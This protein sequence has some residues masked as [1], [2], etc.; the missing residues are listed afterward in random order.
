M[1]ITDSKASFEAHCCRVDPSNTI[2]NLLARNNIETFSALAFAIGT[3]QSPPTD[4]QFR[5][6][7][8]T[9]NGGAELNIGLNSALRRI[10]FEASTMVVAELKSMAV[11]PSGDNVRKLPVAEKLARLQEQEGRL[12]GIR[13]RGELQPSFALVDLVAH[14]KE[15]NCIVWIAPSK[16]SKRDTEIQNSLKE[17]SS[18]LALEQQTLKV[19]SG[20]IP[21]TA[22]TST[23]LQL[24]WALQRRGLAMDQCRL[25]SWNSH[26][27]WVQQIMSQL[28]KD[29]PVGY[30]KISTSQVVKADKELFTLMAQEIQTSVQPLPDGTFP[31]EVKLNELRT[32]PRVTM[33]MLPL[34]K[35]AP[36][37][38]LKEADGSTSPTKKAEVVKKKK[39]L[40]ASAKARSLCPDELKKYPQ[41]D[42]Q[43]NAICWAFNLKGGCK[44]QTSNGRCKKGVHV[45]MKCHRANHS[46]V[47][48]R[49]NN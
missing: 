19:T 30:S 26:E 29:A 8:A 15:T 45:C 6:F 7:G 24:Q 23:D 42:P 3:P 48:C 12:R 11:E 38:N 27:Q 37:D 28:T 10:H 2:K 13:I 22:D 39:K 46:L 4:D 21:S 31:M 43:N 1:A 17:K 47:A 40:Q 20:E 9:L 49:A 34:P 41:R 33:H 44:L 18:V 5:A 35:S 32:D 14:I 16:C 25:I 36:K